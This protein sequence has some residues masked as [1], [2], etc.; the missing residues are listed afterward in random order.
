MTRSNIGIWERA[1]LRWC[2]TEPGINHCRETLNESP[3]WVVSET[4]LRNLLGRLQ[5]VERVYGSLPTVMDAMASPTVERDA[6]GVRPTHQVTRFRWLSNACVQAVAEYDGIFTVAFL[7]AGKWNSPTDLASKLGSRFDNLECT[8]PD[9][10]WDESEQF[11]QFP[12][13]PSLWCVIAEDALAGDDA[14]RALMDIGVDWAR[15]RVIGP[16]IVT[17]RPDRIFPAV[18]DLADQDQTR[19]LGRP[20]RF[21]AWVSDPQYAAMNV[22]LAFRVLD[23]IESWPASRQSA[24]ALMCHESNRNTKKALN[25]LTE[26]R[27]VADFDG[28]HY[29]TDHALIWAS[30]RDRVHIST[31]RSK[32]GSFCVENSHNRR[33]LVRHDSGL[34]NLASR[35]VK[36]QV[37]VFPGWRATTD[38]AGLTQL[39]PDAVVR[40][41][42]EEHGDEWYLLEYE[43][44]ADE[45]GSVENKLSPHLIVAN[46]NLEVEIPLLVVCQDRESEALFW[47]AGRGLR[48]YTTNYHDAIKG[49]LVGEQTVWRQNGRPA[50]LQLPDAP[51]GSQVRPWSKWHV[52][53][54][55]NRSAGRR[56]GGPGR[57]DLS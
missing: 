24:I 22:R 19:A 53:R 20:S 1:K 37:P 15:I 6:G 4:G 42:S 43:R 32:F 10:W 57:F 48:M 45:P 46:S 56:Q 3:P 40:L 52:P 29:L 2:L 9:G 26:T 7:W 17:P 51:V 21:R 5:M 34:A 35:F 25:I 30:R 41:N 18:G 36:Q 55:P 27:L 49:S 33:R 39:N 47:N 13:E 31:L 50:A 14:F 23:A 54:R 12:W 38:F 44:T 11:E 28:H 16:G 8:P